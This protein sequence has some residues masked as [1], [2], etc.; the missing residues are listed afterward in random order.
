MT[1]TVPAAVARRLGAQTLSV[2][3]QGTNLGLWTNYRGLDPSVNARATGNSVTD[4]GVAAPA[5]HLA[6]AGERDLLRPGAGRRA[7]TAAEGASGHDERNGTAHAARASG[8][9][10]APGPR[11]EGAGH[12]AGDRGPGVRGLLAGRPAQE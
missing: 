5:A 12:L 3:V 6:G 10:A 8:G 2:A 11:A 1:Y 7:T 9:A 4:T